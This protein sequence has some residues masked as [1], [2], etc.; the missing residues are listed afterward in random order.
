MKTF[1]VVLR[2]KTR[3]ELEKETA[4]EANEWLTECGYYRDGPKKVK[5][6]YCEAEALPPP[7]GVRL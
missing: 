6:L 5:H 7:L 4:K 1:T 2:D 3:F